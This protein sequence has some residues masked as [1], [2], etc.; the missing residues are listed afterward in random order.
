MVSE[1][2]DQAKQVFK[3][4]NVILVL[5]E[6]V[7]L[8]VSAIGM[9]N[10]M[11]IAL[12]ERT[13]EIGTMKALG[14]SKF[15]IWKMFLTESM[16]IGFMGVVVGLII[17]FLMSKI[18]NFAINVLAKNFGGLTVELFYFPTWFAIFIVIFSTLVGLVTGFYPARR[19]AKLNA[20]EALRYK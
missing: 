14:A 20:L 9:F 7:V 13:Q 12:L 15:D 8:I 16:I 5:F 4:V 10:T 3:V 17:G 2:V 18:L 1:L 19:A 6:A 11:T